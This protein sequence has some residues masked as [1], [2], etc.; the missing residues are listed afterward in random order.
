[1]PVQSSSKKAHNR[2]L[3]KE[4]QTHTLHLKGLKLGEVMA[5]EVQKH[6]ILDW[7][8]PI[9]VT[10]ERDMNYTSTILGDPRQ[11]HSN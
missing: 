10:I 6:I 5:K 4:V 2:T 7:I 8:K 9:G 3:T 11:Y 1:M